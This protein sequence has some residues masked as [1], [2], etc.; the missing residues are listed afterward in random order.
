MAFWKRKTTDADEAGETALVLSGGGARGAYQAGVLAG[1][2]ERCGKHF[3]FRVVTGVSAGAINAAYLAGYSYREDDGN[4]L[5]ASRDLS[6]AWLALTLEHVFRT[7]F[8]SFLESG[9]KWLWTLTMAGRMAPKLQGIFDT[10]PLRE[11]LTQGIE[12]GSIQSNIDSGLLH[13]VAL[14]ATSYST[15][16]TV[17]FV[18]GDSSIKMWRRSGRHS[19]RAK[20]SVDHVMASSALPLIFPAI[21]VGDQFYGD[22]SVRH[23]CPLSPAIHLGA[24]KILSISV[25]YK[26]SAQEARERQIV[27]YPPPGQILGMLFNA[28]FLDSIED[29]EERLLRINRTLDLLPKGTRHPA[30]LRKINFLSLRPSRDL[31]KLSVDLEYSLPKAMR[32]VVR[33]LG[34]L[35][36]KSPDFLSYLLFEQPYVER[37]IELGY[38]DAQNQWPVIEAFLSDDA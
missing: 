37:L 26:R 15:G 8:S 2:G 1:I 22:G 34:V 23:A 11:F 18:Q 36:S 25:G 14:S 33:A 7:D 27:E 13:A 24:S 9:G 6:R 29:D 16:R 5:S 19:K 10:E 12:A 30:G 3:P 21:K 28:I 31:G 35:R 32:R 20:L 17:T 38:N 4:F